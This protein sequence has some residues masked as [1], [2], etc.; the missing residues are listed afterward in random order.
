MSSVRCSLASSSSSRWRSWLLQS[1]SC[2]SVAVTCIFWAV[3]SRSRVASFSE[4]CRASVGK[5]LLADSPKM[6]SSSA[7]ISAATARFPCCPLG[8]GR[9]HAQ[10]PKGLIVARA[11]QELSIDPRQ[12]AP[13]QIHQN[14]L[15]CAHVYIPQLVACACVFWGCLRAL[16]TRRFVSRSIVWSGLSLVEVVVVRLRSGEPRLRDR[17]G[18]LVRTCCK[19]WP[20]A[21]V[22]ANPKWDR[23]SCRYHH[24]RVG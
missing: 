6:L 16:A 18:I 10:R 1:R 3:I 24:R 20:C 8:P 2:S 5:S 4:A 17:H 23:K 15:R 22:L 7:S 21:W 13:I 19:E 9:W 11:R 12:G 14:R